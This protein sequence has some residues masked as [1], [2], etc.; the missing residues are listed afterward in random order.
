M[1]DVIVTLM[2]PTMNR[3][4]FVIRMLNHYAALGFRG[5]IAIG[6]SSS[7]EHLERTRRAIASIGGRLDVV[8]SEMPG[9]GIATCLQRLAEQ[10]TT[11]YATIVPDD[12][13]VVPAA[14]ERCI[15]F[16][17]QHPDYAAAHGAGLTVTLDTNGL[18]GNVVFCAPYPQPVCEDVSPSQRLRDH[19]GQYTVSLFSVHRQ[20]TWRAMWRDVHLMDDVSF[21]AELLPCC[22]SVVH[23]KIKQLEGLYLVRQSHNLRV[24]LPTMFDW[25]ATPLWF[26]SYERTLASLAEALSGREGIQVDAAR[27]VVKD[28]FRDYVGFGLGL[29]R[30]WGRH[31]WM[32]AAARRALRLLRAVR[33]KREE[34]S[35]SALL[36]ASSPHHAD[37]M[38]IYRSL[39]MPPQDSAAPETAI[40]AAG[41]T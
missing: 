33:P 38:P 8:H 22:L 36:N 32:L 11:P 5:R 23:G 39:V 3:S 21:A 34:W 41:G 20:A 15:Q 4:A 26:P 28:G 17:E 19:L 2:V 24:E 12:D 7:A 31:A 10:L 16:L 37:F 30:R 18:T 27:K 6:D 13:F 9:F 25:M 35:L 14:V 29:R 40:V 1:N